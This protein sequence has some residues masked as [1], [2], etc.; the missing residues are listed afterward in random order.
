MTTFN[1]NI[2]EQK[3]YIIYTLYIIVIVIFKKYLKVKGELGTMFLLSN[4]VYLYVLKFVYS[5]SIKTTDDCGQ[6]PYETGF[7]RLK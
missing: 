6:D 3:V 2:Q 5:M 4:F 7:S 1:K